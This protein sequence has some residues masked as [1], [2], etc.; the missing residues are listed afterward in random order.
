MVN[1]AVAQERRSWFRINDGVKLVYRFLSDLELGQLR[2]GQ[3][4]DQYRPFGMCNEVG[5]FS[6]EIRRLRPEIQATDSSLL[7][8]LDAMD[9]KMDALFGL[10][11][12]AEQ[13]GKPKAIR[14]VNIGAGG[15]AFDA[16][17]R[18]E[19]EKHVELLLYLQPGN[20]LVSALAKIVGWESTFAEEGVENYRVSTSFTDISDADRET[21]IRHVL[22]K[23]SEKLLQERRPLGQQD[24]LS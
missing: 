5:Y 17:S 9:A 6:A 10:L 16:E 3:D 2:K 12:D 8:M 19:Q 21:L 20:V 18:P 24:Q 14:E 1:E 23:Q 13:R 15:I 7:K 11:L 4:A 22:K